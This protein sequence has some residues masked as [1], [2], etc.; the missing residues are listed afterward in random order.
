MNEFR[1]IKDVEEKCCQLELK[2]PLPDKQSSQMT[3]TSFKVAS[4]AVLTEDK[5][6]HK[7][8]STRKN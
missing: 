3:G 4:Y 8:M 5:H 6:N 2:Q 7:F 1:E